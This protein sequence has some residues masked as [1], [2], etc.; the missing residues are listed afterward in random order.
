MTDVCIACKRSVEGG[1]RR[2]RK[3]QRGGFF[4]LRRVREGGKNSARC[5]VSIFR[6]H[7]RGSGKPKSGNRI[8]GVGMHGMEEGREFFFSRRGIRSTGRHPPPSAEELQ[9][10]FLGKPRTRRSAAKK[11]RRSLFSNPVYFIWE[12]YSISSLLSTFRVLL[13]C[14]EKKKLLGGTKYVQLRIKSMK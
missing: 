12:C 7:S 11:S 2:R 6:S 8:T 13:S 3:T 1:I 4:F 10:I 14:T 5:A 9:Q